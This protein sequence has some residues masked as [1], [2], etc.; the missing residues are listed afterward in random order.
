MA[1]KSSNGVAVWLVP[2]LIVLFVAGFIVYILTE[3]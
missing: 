3:H 2:L 1:T